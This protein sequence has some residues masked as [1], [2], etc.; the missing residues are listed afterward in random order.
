MATFLFGCLIGFIFG[1]SSGVFLMGIMT[2][3]NRTDV[4]NKTASFID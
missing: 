1:G 4:N 3:T 2:A